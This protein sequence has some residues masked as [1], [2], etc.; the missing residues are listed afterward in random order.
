MMLSIQLCLILGYSMDQLFPQFP[1]LYIFY[2]LFYALVGVG[3][4]GVYLL[5]ILAA[6]FPFTADH[7]KPTESWSK[8]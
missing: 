1:I 8:F 4:D 5:C 2:Q 6:S 3:F 7:S